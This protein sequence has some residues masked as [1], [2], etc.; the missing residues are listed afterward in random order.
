MRYQMKPLSSHPV[1]DWFEKW[2]KVTFRVGI[3]CL[4]AFLLG[5]WWGYN[6][7]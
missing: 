2:A 7:R 3:M 5:I 6:L 4:V 1:Q